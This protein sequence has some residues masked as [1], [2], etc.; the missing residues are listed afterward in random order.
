MLT[1]TLTL[2][3]AGVAGSPFTLKRWKE[4]DGTSQYGVRDAV[5]EIIVDIR[6]QTDKANGVPVYRHNVAFKHTV[7]A[8]L[9]APQK[10]NECSVT[11][12]DSQ[13]YGPAQAIANWQGFNTLLLTIDDD[14]IGGDV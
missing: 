14:V 3:L 6:Q 5:Q 4:K 9:V 1:N 13:G 12:R 2:T 8:T 10:F 11:V 7:F